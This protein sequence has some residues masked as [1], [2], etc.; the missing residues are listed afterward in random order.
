MSTIICHLTEIN[1]KLKSQC[2]RVSH[3]T[4]CNIISWSYQASPWITCYPYA[5]WHR[6][7][8]MWYVMS[9]LKTENKR[10]Q[11]DISKMLHGHFQNTNLCNLQRGPL[12]QLCQLHISMD[13]RS[14][15]C[16]TWITSI[17]FSTSM[18]LDVAACIQLC[19]D[20]QAIDNTS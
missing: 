13:L 15:T 6:I 11:Q 18:S 14:F 16:I 4:E 10:S 3:L 5:L 8:D 7:L 19:N 9:D 1:I 17:C 12:R 2:P 20:H